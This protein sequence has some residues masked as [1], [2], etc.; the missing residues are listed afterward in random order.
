MRLQ[1]K[2]WYIEKLINKIT[3]EKFKNEKHKL[4]KRGDSK[5]QR[6]AANIIG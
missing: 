4:V 3:L 6:P 2:I 1:R 5:E